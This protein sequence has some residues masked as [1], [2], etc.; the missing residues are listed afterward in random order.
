MATGHRMNRSEFCEFAMRDL[1]DELEGEAKFTA[2]A[3]TAIARAGQ[4]SGDGIFVDEAQRLLIAGTE[5]RLPEGTGS[6][7]SRT[8]A[9]LGSRDTT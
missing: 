4:P 1:A 3:S 6:G 8:V 5:W 2:L 9:P 7:G